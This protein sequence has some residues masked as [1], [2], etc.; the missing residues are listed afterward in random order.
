MSARVRNWDSSFHPL[1]KESGVGDGVDIDML[2][3]SMS[4][5]L[6]EGVMTGGVGSVEEIEVL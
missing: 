4:G 6:I 2:R 5:L 1:F 3:G